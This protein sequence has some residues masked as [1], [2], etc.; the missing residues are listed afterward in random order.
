MNL[1]TQQQ[2]ALDSPAIEQHPLI[3]RMV[4]TTRGIGSERTN[5]FFAT[6]ASYLAS[7]ACGAAVAY[8]FDRYF[9]FP[10]SL[11]DAQGFPGEW[12][13][14]VGTAIMTAFLLGLLFPLLFARTRRPL[15]LLL[16]II[17]QFITLVV[18]ILIGL[19]QLPVTA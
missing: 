15:A 1:P 8:F 7:M 19:S 3:E 17:L 14:G 6:A 12:K 5:V 4:E 16:T 2:P 11:S 13:V 10:R 9:G 18:L